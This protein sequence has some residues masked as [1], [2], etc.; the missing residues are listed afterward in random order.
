MVLFWA[1]TGSVFGAPSHDGL[2]YVDPTLFLSPMDLGHH[3]LRHVVASDCQDLFWRQPWYKKANVALEQSH[4]GTT[5]ARHYIVST[6]SSD[7]CELESEFPWESRT[8]AEVNLGY[9]RFPFTMTN[10]R[11]GEAENPGP[12]NQPMEE[13]ACLLAIGTSNPSGLRRKEAIAIEMGAGIWS[14]S[15]THLTS[16]TSRTCCYYMKQ[17]ALQQNRQVKL[18]V[19]H[20]AALRAH[21]QW[22]GTWTGVAQLTDLPST[23]ISI[24]VSLEQWKS[25]RLLV[26]RQWAS[27]LPI[28]FCSYYAYPA[29]PT[30]PK[31]RSLNNTLLEHLTREVVYGTSG[32]RVIAGDFNS[33][34]G[35]FGA[36]KDMAADGV[37][38]RPNLWVSIPWA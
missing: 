4:L 33:S 10:H 36:A 13:N 8:R 7:D 24:D 38:Q 12:L 34:P 25:S 28:T 6:A 18:E 19:G 22:A 35:S 11:I 5:L 2:R 29:G 3:S 16:Q 14:F 31:A 30:W 21:S 26:A 1:L 32:V 20:P 9:G 37:G 15:E 27:S 17:L 23:R